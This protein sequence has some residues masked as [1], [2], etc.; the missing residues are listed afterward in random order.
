MGLIITPTKSTNLKPKL[1]KCTITNSDHRVEAI[2]IVQ[3]RDM[4]YDGILFEGGT[5]IDSFEKEQQLVGN[6]G[7]D[8]IGAI[9]SY[10][11]LDNKHTYLKFMN[12][13]LSN[14]TLERLA[15]I[16]EKT[17]TLQVFTIDTFNPIISQHAQESLSFAIHTNRDSLQV[18]FVEGMTTL[19]VSPYEFPKIG[20]VTLLKNKR[21]V[22]WKSVLI[23]VFTIVFLGSL[24]FGIYYFTRN[25]LASAVLFFFCVVCIELLRT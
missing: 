20:R 24:T 14:E 21:Y 19:P 22:S 9:E 13:N 3:Y 16:I 2:R 8:M 4:K 7:N 11:I 6:I 25:A 15:K 5:S 17:T 23:Y 18:V 1:Y 10:L 12:C